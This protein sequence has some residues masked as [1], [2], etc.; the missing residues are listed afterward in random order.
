LTN[1]HACELAAQKTRLVAES[2]RLHDRDAAEIQRLAGEFTALTGRYQML[3]TSILST[4]SSAGASFAARTDPTFEEKETAVQSDQGSNWQRVQRR[5]I[6]EE[7]E[8]YEHEQKIKRAQAQAGRVPT[9]PEPRP[10]E[11]PLARNDLARTN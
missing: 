9:P 1:L 11:K 7:N 10:G 3:E 5:M 4:S 6:R 2:Q 8:R